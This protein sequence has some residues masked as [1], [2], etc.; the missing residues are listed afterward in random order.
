MRPWCTRKSP[1]AVK[2]QGLMAADTQDV[3][4]L[5]RR[6]KRGAAAKLAD[7]ASFPLQASDPVSRRYGRNASSPHLRLTPARR[8]GGDLDARRLLRRQARAPMRKSPLAFARGLG[9]FAA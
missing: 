8:R 5:S 6:W 9:V 1:A 4:H 3:Q 2:P 7:S